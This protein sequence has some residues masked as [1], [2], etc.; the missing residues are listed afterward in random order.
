VASETHKLALNTSIAIANRVLDEVFAQEA[1]KKLYSHVWAA[2]PLNAVDRL[3]KGE[4]S[5]NDIYGPDSH[6]TQ[7]RD[8]IENL[9]INEPSDPYIAFAYFVH[10]DAHRLAECRAEVRQ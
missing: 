5:R 10:G 2:L 8:D 7:V 1:S 6:Y 3:A 9:I 4:F